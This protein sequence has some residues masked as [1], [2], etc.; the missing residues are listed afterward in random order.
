MF[1]GFKRRAAEPLESFRP[2]PAKFAIAPPGACKSE[3]RQIAEI[4]V[5]S[6]LCGFFTGD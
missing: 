4:V 2:I 3:P 1:S 6:A 5:N